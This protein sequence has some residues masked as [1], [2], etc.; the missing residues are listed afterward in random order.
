MPATVTSDPLGITCVF[1]DGT[2]MSR[3]ISPA[4][5]RPLAED[6][7]TGLAGLVHPH[8]NVD[9]AAT[10]GQYVAALRHMVRALGDRGFTGG[11]AQL[12]R[13]AL[14][15]YWMGA[16][17]SHEGCT[18]RMLRAF[19]AA[20]GRCT[21]HVRQLAAG[22]AYNP[23]PSY[24]PLRPYPETEWMLLRQ[25]CDTVTAE[26]FTAH[27]AAL[28]AAARGCDPAAGGWSG[29]N[30][31]WLLSRAGPSTRRDVAAHAGC[32]PGEL[33]PGGEFVQASTQLFPHLDVVIAYQLLFGAYSGV[34]PDGIADLTVGDIEW[35]GDAAVLLAY[36]KGRTGAESLNLP[37][38]AVRLLEQ[39]LSHSALLRSLVPADKQGQLWLGVTAVGSASVSGGRRADPV[40][41]RRWA[42][43]HGLTGDDGQPLRIHRQRIRT[44]HYAMRDRQ[45]WT[46][47]GRA[48]IDPNHSPQLEGDRYLTAATPVQQQAVDTIIED[49]QH[50]MLRKAHPPTVVTDAQAAALARDFPQLVAGLKLDDSVIAELAGGQRDVFVAACADQLSGLHG[51]KGKPCPA[52]PWVC[53]ACPLAVFAPRHAAN[54]LRLKAFFA[55]QWQARPAA[56]FMA[57]FGPYADRIGQILDRYHPAVLAAA[58]SAVTGHDTELPLRPEELSR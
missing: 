43:R 51:P 28:A 57:V 32:S 56:E 52:R 12:T 29:D 16:P 36:V 10:A 40:T 44:T 24:P 58:A 11:A 23:V 42:R 31:R 49:A 34:V 1:S 19:D 15:A 35:A 50:D 54:L 38:R 25:T 22:R 33:R 21:T 4:G 48:T 45:G 46:G 13:P 53:L 39:W 8:G 5:C 27:R 2:V 3:A 20:T 17:S 55:R 7:L 30:L 6:L 14:A 41:V 47:S 26:A 18:R 37:K 9:A